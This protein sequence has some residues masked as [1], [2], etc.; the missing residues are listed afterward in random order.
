V[1]QHQGPN[2]DSFK[3]DNAL[4]CAVRLLFDVNTS[5]MLSTHFLVYENSV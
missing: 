2:G 3:P 5:T 1:Q 4:N